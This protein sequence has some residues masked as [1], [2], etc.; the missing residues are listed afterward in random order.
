MLFDRI[1]FAFFGKDDPFRSHATAK[2]QPIC[3][4]SD[5]KHFCSCWTDSG[6]LSHVP[7]FPHLYLNCPGVLHCILQATNSRSTWF[8][9]QALGFSSLWCLQSTC[10]SGNARH[11]PCL[12]AQPLQHPGEPK[13]VEA[14]GATL[15]RLQHVSFE[16]CLGSCGSTSKIR[17]AG[18]D[19][20]CQA[21]AFV[22]P[23]H[24][25]SYAHF[26]TLWSCCTFIHKNC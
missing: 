16:R 20:I 26:W 24:E 12:R 13:P 25:S 6:V 14:H 21:P 4:K 10:S 8:V 23:V 11:P 5:F 15:A 17:E 19:C 3:S 9:G 2:Q 1:A 7:E 18:I 22:G